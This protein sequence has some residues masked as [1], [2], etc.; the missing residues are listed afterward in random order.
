MRVW[1]V[2]SSPPA[3]ERL[4]SLH[5]HVHMASLQLWKPWLLRGRGTTQRTEVH[6]QKKLFCSLLGPWL[7]VPTTQAASLLHASFVELDW[8]LAPGFCLVGCGVG[9]TVT[10][11]ASAH[12]F[13]IC[14]RSSTPSS[15]THAAGL[16][17]HVNFTL[18]GCHGVVP[19]V[20]VSSQLVWP[21]AVWKSGLCDNIH[22]NEQSPALSRIVIG[23]PQPTQRKKTDPAPDAPFFRSSQLSTSRGTWSLYDFMTGLLLTSLA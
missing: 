11:V 23:F 16:A 2:F 21:V 5:E 15:S 22:F 10:A 13:A 9:S 7:L 20:N 12:Q 18:R 1:C 4:Q 17:W 14:Q 6:R 3:G 19:W 8:E